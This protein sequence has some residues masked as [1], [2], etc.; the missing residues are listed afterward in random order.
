MRK[1]VWGVVQTM[2]CML[3]DLLPNLKNKGLFLGRKLGEINVVSKLRVPPAISSIHQTLYS[4]IAAFC[5]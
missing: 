3:L 4:E 1:E 5:L 2:V